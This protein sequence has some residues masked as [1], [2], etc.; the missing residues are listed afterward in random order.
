[1]RESKGPN[2]EQIEK[3]AHELFLERGGGD[4][5]DTED[6]L[7]A[8]RELTEGAALKAN[9]PVNST[10]AE[11]KS[12]QQAPGVDGEAQ[13]GEGRLPPNQKSGAAGA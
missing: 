1:M 6:W 3:R 11:K 5:L 9:P 2:R 7:A 8:E 10:W 4:G 13:I 12:Q